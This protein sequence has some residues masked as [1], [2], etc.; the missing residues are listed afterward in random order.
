[1]ETTEE[2]LG[3]LGLDENASERDIRSAYARRLK[4]IDQEQDPEGFGRLRAAY[5]V[6]LD[7][8]AWRRDRDH[9]DAPA[10]APSAPLAAADRPAPPEAPWQ[11]TPP[12]PRALAY[13]VLDRMIAKLPALAAASNARQG[14][15]PWAQELLRRLDDEELINIDARITFEAMVASILAQGWRPGHEHLFVAAQEV[16]GWNADRQRLR[17]FGQA[18]ALLDAALAE[19]ELLLSM[20]VEQQRVLR[21]IAAA[22][23]E[24]APP[25]L[26]RIRAG[27]GS[28]EMLT[29][30]FPALTRVTVSVENVEHWRA[31]YHEHGGAPS[32][33]AI[34]PPAPPGLMQ[35]LKQAVSIVLLT[36]AAYVFLHAVFTSVDDKQPA[37]VAPAAPAVSKQV[38][39]T[40]VPPV[41]FK[42][43]PATRPG[44]VETRVRVYLDESMRVV[45]TM[46]V[47]TSGEPAFD[48][49]V[50]EALEAAKPFPP[51]TPREF[52]LTFSA[53]VTPSTPR[54]APRED[55]LPA[56]QRPPAP[57]ALAPPN[58]ALLR[59]HIPPVD[60][61]PTRYAKE[62]TLSL[63]YQVYLNQKGRVDRVRQLKGSGDPRLDSAFEAAL[64]AA[65]PFPATTARSF[66]VSWSTT[67]SA[68]KRG[69]PASAP[70]KEPA[71]E[72]P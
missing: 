55:P 56:R 64:R 4:R 7:W 12:D 21:T 41:R 11:E 68:R 2:F 8:A 57:P 10:P 52:E 25:E 27:M 70:N 49:G 67:I 34:E 28:V 48:R 33:A 60:Y 69:A 58:A 62:G 40:T 42:P 3:L 71:P 20:P 13:A 15:T 5:E 59:K 24:T 43:G 63:D 14:H 22:L 18:G 23:R 61:Q 54:E 46:N 53:M 16:F 31:T 30:R 51:G 65:K 47:L 17:Q 9:T 38:L 66:G 50:K 39:E 72:Q 45:R 26:R 35:R 6:A 32:E 19:R 44:P 29:E 37:S 1:M 36:V